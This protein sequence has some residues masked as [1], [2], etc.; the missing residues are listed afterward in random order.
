MSSRLA[1]L[2]VQE[3]L[4]SPKRMADAFQRQV[5]YGGTLDTILLEMDL[6]EETTLL[7]ALTRAT[8][9]PSAGSLPNLQP[10][11]DPK[12]AE[13]LPAAAAER[14]HVAPIELDG[15]ILRVLVTD[16]VDRKLLDELGFQARRSV[17]PLITVEYRFHQAMHEVYG[18]TMPARYASLEARLKQRRTEPRRP[19]PA[20]TGAVTLPSRAVVTDV[21]MPRAAPPQRRVSET[22]MPIVR[23][24]RDTQSANLTAGRIEAH[25]LANVDPRV[26]PGPHTEGRADYGR[27]DRRSEA[28]TDPGMP[29]IPGSA[30]TDPPT[31]RL[32]PTRQADA[33]EAPVPPTVTVRVTG[34]SASEAT[35]LKVQDALVLLEEAPDR[36][37]VFELLC[38]AARSR[39]SF[40]AVF[41]IH[42]DVAVPR[43]ALA[44]GW[45]DRQELSRIAIPLDKPSPFRATIEGRASYLGRLFEDNA[46][47]QPLIALGRPVPTGIMLLPL[48]LR[49]R[50]V[51]LLYADAGGEAIQTGLLS[52]LNNLM[53]AASRAFQRI[54][55]KQKSSEFRSGAGSSTGKVTVTSPPPARTASGSW[56][57]A[58][59]PI[60]EAKVRTT[61]PRLGDRF[62][63][64]DP[65]PVDPNDLVAVFLRGG[66]PAASAAEALVALGEVGASAVVAQLPGPL[67]F[68]RRAMRG[69]VPP[70]AEHGPLL[71]LLLRFGV[72][73]APPLLRRLNDPTIDA[74]YYAT[75][76]A[77][78]L[79]APE[80]VRSLGQRLF[81]PDASV[82]QVA[83][84]SLQRFPRSQELDTLFESLRGELPGP[85]ALRQRF[86]AEA[87]GALADVLALPRLI[88]LCKHFDA[89]VSTAAQQALVAIT[90]QDFGTSRWRWRSWW[91]RHRHEPRSEWLLEGLA[92]G[93]AEIRRGSIAELQAQLPERFGY[94]PDGDRRARDDARRKILDWWRTNHRDQ[95]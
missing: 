74:R 2:L 95:F 30:I 93:E 52:G 84:L 15:N 73:A 50:A 16:P 61:Q 6:I 53:N 71:A 77:G 92:S 10:L 41:T 60:V 72:T 90:K 11:R 25:G 18:T 43:L 65:R 66:E 5:I 94:D 23:I 79:A 28:R 33:P 57:P 55:L 14:Y 68:D 4:V 64:A 35:T 22:S 20:S 82:R 51:A 88:E 29:A 83:A 42:N 9:L 56:Q 45:L 32:L 17:D 76:L 87:C 27:A 24:E 3:A 70:V 12:F 58:L 86:A 80:L 31:A 34:A 78:E 7:E 63:A 69:P 91:E 36:D 81:D 8:S 54:I 1:S 62:S 46:A 37:T 48:V 44:G 85:D 59:A 21:P 26:E 67:N 19:A 47:S 38:R 75:L 13:I 39:L 49:D 89:N 40:A